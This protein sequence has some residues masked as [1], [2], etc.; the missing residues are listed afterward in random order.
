MIIYR[1]DANDSKPMR[2]LILIATILA[3]FALKGAAQESIL[4]RKIRVDNNEGTVG[5]F[6]EEISSKGGF[7]FSYNQEVPLDRMASVSGSRQRVGQFLNDIFG[8]DVYC[9]EYSNKLHLKVRRK[10]PDAYLVTGRVVESETGEAIP[11]ANVIVVGSDPLIGVITGIHGF[12]ELQLPYEKPRIR[13]TSIGYETRDIVS[14]ANNPDEIALQVKKQEIREVSVMAYTLPTSKKLTIATGN[15]AGSRIAT[16]PGASIEQL[17]QGNTS[18]LF[19]TSNSGMP[20]SSFQVRIRGSHSLINSEPAYFLNGIPIQKALVN[21]IS[22]DDIAS[23][24][25]IKDASGSSI[26]GATAGNGVVLLTSKRGEPG[27]TRFSVNAYAG[28]QQVNREMDMMDSDAFRE[29]H[30]LVGLPLDESLRDSPYNTNWQE[31]IFHP[32]ETGNVH[33]SVSGSSEHTDY[34]VSLAAMKQASVLKNLDLDRYTFNSN[35]GHMLT[36]RWRIRHQLNYA[37]MDMNGLV[38]GSFLNDQ[39]NPVLSSITMYPVTPPIDSLLDYYNRFLFNLFTDT[40]ISFD[41]IFNESELSRNRREN[42]NLTGKLSS[43]LALTPQMEMVTDIGYVLLYQDNFSVHRGLVNR[44]ALRGTRISETS[45]QVMDLGLD[46]HNYLRWERNIS[47]IHLLTAMAGVELNRSTNEWIP[48][49]QD[50]VYPFLALEP[51][52]YPN[53]SY[54]KTSAIVGYNNVA[55]SAMFTYAYNNRLFLKSSLRNDMVLFRNQAGENVVFTDLYP[56]L[57]GAWLFLDRSDRG[58]SSW[59]N[60]G[61]IRYAWGMAGNSPRLDYAFHANIFRDATYLYAFSSDRNV[62]YSASQR[63]FNE[64]F[65]WEKSSAHNLGIELGLFEN[66]LYGSVDLFYNH[67]QKGEL[68]DYN[69][70]FNMI[71]DLYG[72]DYLGLAPLPPAGVLSRGI[73][74][75]IVYKSAEGNLRW[76]MNLHATHMQNRILDIDPE[77][78]D[79]INKG[80]IDPLTVNLP[81]ETP[82]SFYGYRIERLFTEDDCSEDG[83]VVNQPFYYDDEENK[84]YAQPGAKAGDYKFEDITPDNIIDSK[85]KTVLGD[86]YPDIIFGY[87]LNMHYRQFDLSMLWHG[88]WGNEIFNATKLWLYNPQGTS[89]WTTDMWNSYRSQVYDAEGN[90]VDEGFTDT[91]LHRFDYDSRNRNLRTSD[92]YIEDG[93]YLRLKQIQLGYAFRHALSKKMHLEK[94]RIYLSARNLFTYTNYS[95]YDPEVGGWGIDSGIYPQPRTFYAGVD[96]GF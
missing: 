72:R 37:Y 6:L 52:V 92:F 95:G 65:Y 38:E 71:K 43:K 63:Q 11:G 23:V 19:V 7:V 61:K 29:F 76:D 45:Y 62:A 14:E 24:E 70:P 79:L 36:P 32:G 21:A 5:S 75:S 41:V 18:G 77:Y 55:E 56:S 94:F 27:K 68:S 57:S 81:G 49:A 84:R 78:Y 15:I 83:L 42:H 82:G 35:V 93:S 59:L 31:Q 20:G 13:I 16:Q 25:I 66:R 46:V 44:G 17:L 67:Q 12:F 86:P 89:N 80:F 50:F 74:W 1:G 69:N 28:I 3:L 88:T 58:E 34:Y 91:G 8:D 96:I 60:Y 40:E 22:P 85:D 48:V 4:D 73:E 30:D 53:E 90:L 2:K 39:N 51:I 47:D 10:L 54:S 64:K 33:F 9:V 26:Y 87:T